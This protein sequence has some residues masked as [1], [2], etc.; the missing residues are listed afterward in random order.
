MKKK[1]L[2]ILSLLMIV[3]LIAACGSNDVSNAPETK[4]EDTE[5][6][7]SVKNT[8]SSSSKTIKAG[9]GLNE[10]HPQYKGMELFK[11]IVEK[12]TDGEII[13]EIYPSAQL[14]DDKQMIQAVQ[15]G[16]Q[17]VTVPAT[18]P[19]ANFVPEFNIVNF[20]FLFPNAKV[21][22]A[23]LDGDTGQMLLDKLENYGM[24]GLSYW[25]EGFY[26][27]SNSVRPIE[28][29][30]DLKGIKIRTMENAILLDIFTTLGANP[31]PMAFP[32]VYTALQQGVVDAQTNPVSQIY[33][34]KF[35]EVQDYVSGTNDYYGVWVFLINK[36]FFEGL[37]AEQ[38]EIV[39]DASIKARDLERQLTRD[40]EQEYLEK[41]QAEG[42]K[43][44]ELSEDGRKS[45][46]EKIQPVVDKYSKDIQDVADA[47]YEAIEVERSK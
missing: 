3:V 17:E 25:E 13:V 46:E 31:T 44:N 1:F 36:E 7:N 5:A 16:T 38:Q 6:N 19:L 8:G 40:T 10:D 43:Y 24:V 9:I 22:D 37:T 30:D 47:F 45:I 4:T 39:K 11:E 29:V 26:N 15:L 2:I 21:A 28:S 23:V 34:A 27:I 14:G 42:V 12:E 33:E 35:H 32:E 18:A 20:P 41:L